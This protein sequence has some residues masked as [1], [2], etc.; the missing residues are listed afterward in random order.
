MLVAPAWCVSSAYA[1]GSIGLRW[2]LRLLE[3]F[4]VGRLGCGF[5]RCLHI[6]QPMGVVFGYNLVRDRSAGFAL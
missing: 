4:V 2:P 3:A 6:F 5:M 1:G